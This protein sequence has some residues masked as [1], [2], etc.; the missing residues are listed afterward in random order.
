MR[1]SQR[2]LAL[3]TVL[4]LAACGAP[5]T[6]TKP[7]GGATAGGVGAVLAPPTAAPAAALTPERERLLRDL[8][9][10]ANQEG[11]LEAEVND[12]A[13]PAAGAIKDAFVNKFKPYGLNVAVNVGAGQQPAVW[14]NAQAAIAAGAA[15]QFDAMLGQ[16]DSEVLP[17]MKDGML[18]RIDNWQ[19]LLAA[20]DPGVAS[21]RVKPEER[22][23]EPFTGQGFIFDDRLKIMLYNTE[24]TSPDRLPKTYVEMADPRFK[25]QYPVPPW[26]TTFGTG[27]VYYGKDRW[28]EILTGIGQNATGVATYTAGAQQMLAKQITFQ[29]DN[30][31]DYYTQKS[32][33]ANVPVD[34]AWFGD[35]TGLNTQYYVVPQRAKHPA[36]ATLFAMYM[37]TDEG[38][39]SMAPAYTGINVRA[40]HL[41]VDDHIRQGIA[42]S[43]TKVVDFFSTPDAR[44]TLEWFQTPDGDAYVDRMSKA[45]SRRG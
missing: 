26:P 45:L 30:L 40:G 15:P 4:L 12:S 8:V 17:R 10:R 21:G 36:A 25:G 19:E 32:L 14:A 37:A 39:A 41:P 34:Y 5:A 23:P 42:E 29:H 27:V 1:T 18:Q 31:G 24:L 9:A 38:R 11:S 3:A 22:S 2:I 6:T 33:G 35:F 28:L 43:K 44:A 7:S 13:M 16:D 20:I